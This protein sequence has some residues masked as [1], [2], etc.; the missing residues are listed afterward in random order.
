LEAEHAHLHAQREQLEAEI[1]A[2]ETVL[3]AG[4]REPLAK[5]D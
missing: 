1:R 4:T 2:L 5:K 3:D